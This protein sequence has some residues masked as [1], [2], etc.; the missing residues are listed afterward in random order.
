MKCVF[1]FLKYPIMIT[2]SQWRQN[3]LQFFKIQTWLCKAFMSNLPNNYET[4]LSFLK[5]KEIKLKTNLFQEEAMY[6]TTQI[7]GYY[8]IQIIRHYT[9]E[10]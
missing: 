4:V 1:F 8:M 7:T 6:N 2:T 5:T 3:Y 10:I 9:I